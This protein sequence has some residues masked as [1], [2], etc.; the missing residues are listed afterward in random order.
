MIGGLR[1]A[2]E[3]GVSHEQMADNPCDL[4]PFIV[5]P[6]HPE[7]VDVQVQVGLQALRIHPREPPEAA[8]YPGAQVVGERHRL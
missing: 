8:L 4:G 6:L 5:I 3:T 7:Q 2:A 1:R